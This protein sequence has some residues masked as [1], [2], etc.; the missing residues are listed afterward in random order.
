MNDLKAYKDSLTYL[1]HLEAILKV[2]NLSMKT[3]IPFKHFVGVYRILV[4]MEEEK[5]LLEMHRDKFKKI[6]ESKGLVEEPV[7]F[8]A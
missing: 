1:P 7:K 4:V 2:I 3:L 5:Q 6:K 8:E